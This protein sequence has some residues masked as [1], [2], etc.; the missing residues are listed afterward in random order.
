MHVMKETGLNRAYSLSKLLIRAYPYM[1]W[2][3]ELMA[4]EGEMIMIQVT[5]DT[6]GP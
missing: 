3:E 6:T 5:L 1:N 4:K 2:E